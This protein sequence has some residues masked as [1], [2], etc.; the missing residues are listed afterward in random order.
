M[1]SVAR[2]NN[3][4]SSA[5][6]IMASIRIKATVI[7]FDQGNTLLMDPFPAIMQLQKNRFCQV[8][9][10]LG[11]L[12]D[13]ERIVSEWTR[14]NSRIHYPHIGHFYQEEPIVH[15]ALRNLDAREDIAVIL[16]LELLREYRIGLRKVIESDPRTQEVRT[17][18][19]E[20]RSRGKRLGVFSND[21]TVALDF[22]LN[23]MGV[24]PYFEYIE[25]SE[26]IAVEKPDPRVFEHILKFFGTEP[27]R[28]SYVGDDPT[29]DIEAAKAQGLTAIRYRVGEETY[30]ESWRNY[31]VKTKCEPD[32]SIDRF[33]ELLEIIK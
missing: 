10:G 12:A 16:G 27:N 31:G 1:L 24:R 6:E 20:L 18:I 3:P 29:R 13:T 7:V 33:S 21:R 9:E 4:H 22:V 28:V 26:S 23:I 17:T 5:R 25:T 30:H 15:D 2:T 19:E 8:C 11:I 32:A 14:S